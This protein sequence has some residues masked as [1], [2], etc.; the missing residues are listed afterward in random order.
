[1]RLIQH[2]RHIAKPC[3]HPSRIDT[4]NKGG[5]TPT[6]DNP[7]PEDFVNAV[8]GRRAK[9]LNFIKFDLRPSLFEG[10]GGVLIGHD[11][12]YDYAY[13]P[14]QWFKAPGVK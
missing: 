10:S 2:E 6:P 12:K 13:E 5:D 1:M 7:T 4:R 3:N 14:G 9:G 11:A 8:Q